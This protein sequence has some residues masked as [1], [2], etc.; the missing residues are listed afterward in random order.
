M[1]TPYIAEAKHVPLSFLNDYLNDFPK[2][3]KFYLHFAGGY[4]SVIAASILKSRGIHN[5][6]EVDEG[7][8][9]IKNTNITITS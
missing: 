2:D 4:R 5:V 3:E 1:L 6:V 7:F 9:A 8:A